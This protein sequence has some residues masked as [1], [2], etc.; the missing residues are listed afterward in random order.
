MNQSRTEVDSSRR[1]AWAFTRL[2]LIGYPQY[3]RMRKRC[4]LFTLFF[5]SLVEVKL[6]IENNE[7]KCLSQYEEVI[8]T[9]K[10][11]VLLGFSY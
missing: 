5:L 11:T 9:N 8:C 7:Y 6:T 3:L 4:R 1:S 2:R 10:N